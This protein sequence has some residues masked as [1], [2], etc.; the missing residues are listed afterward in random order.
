MIRPPHPQIDHTKSVSIIRMPL[1]S[2]MAR[3]EARPYEM[4]TIVREAAALYETKPYEQLRG[5]SKSIYEV[6]CGLQWVRQP[7][8]WSDK[9]ESVQT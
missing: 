7:K 4:G 8:A 5:S 3:L 1:L 2:Q 6:E 9:T